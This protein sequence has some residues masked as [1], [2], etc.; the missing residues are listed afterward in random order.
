MIAACSVAFAQEGGAPP[1]DPKAMME[2]MAKIAAPG[3]QHAF[4]KKLDGKWNLDVTWT[5][6]P[7]QPPQKSKSTCTVKSLMDGRYSHEQATGQM[8][9]QSFSGMGITGYDNV[10]KKF[11]SIWIDNMGTGIMRSEGTMADD[12]KTIN[13][14]GESSDPMTGGISKMRMVT[15]FTDDNHHTFDMYGA[16][17]D[18]KEAKM[19]TIAY[20]RAK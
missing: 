4:L 20:T 5:M 17:P 7:S 16:M 11:V 8:M 3:P 19:M 12:G 15:T 9:G 2:M 10:L 18:G 1:A 13:W 14:Q 6:D